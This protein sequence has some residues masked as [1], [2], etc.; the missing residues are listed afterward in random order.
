[1]PKSDSRS[2][3]PSNILA[4]SPLADR[5]VVKPITKEETSSFGIIIPDTA[6]KERPAK[7]TV[8]AIG[9]GKTEDGKLFPVTV[10]IGQTVLFSKYGYDEVKIDGEEYFILTESSI[11]AIINK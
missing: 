8:V 9:P 2:G 10:K 11:L 1:M 6:D 3:S 4:I 5:V 7:G